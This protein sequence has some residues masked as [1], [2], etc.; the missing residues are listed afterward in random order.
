MLI[1]ITLCLAFHYGYADCR[2][3]E[4]HY[5]ECCFAECHFPDSGYAERHFPE[6]CYAECCCILKKALSI[7]GHNKIMHF[8]EILYRCLWTQTF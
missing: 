2:C 7:Q 8:T 3:L 1:V 5:D 4:C 6:S